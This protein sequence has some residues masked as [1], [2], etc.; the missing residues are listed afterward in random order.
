VNVVPFVRLLSQIRY[1]KYNDGLIFLVF[2]IN[3]DR[4]LYRLLILNLFY[5]GVFTH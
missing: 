3:A 4:C 5:F 1:S 2:C